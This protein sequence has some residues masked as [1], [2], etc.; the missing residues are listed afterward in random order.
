M[1]IMGFG[2]FNY[3]TFTE[4]FTIHLPIFIE[5]SPKRSPIDNVT[6]RIPISRS[7]GSDF[8]EIEKWSNKMLTET[9]NLG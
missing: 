2:I 7:K 3:F 4:L 5:V 6:I 8:G 9:I 1:K